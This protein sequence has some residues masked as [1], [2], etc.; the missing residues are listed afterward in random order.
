MAGSLALGPAVAAW[1]AAP[2]AAPA[3]AC[4]VETTADATKVT[5][6]GDGF[7][8][9]KV[10]LD[11]TDGAGGGSATVQSDG[12]FKSGEVS[13]G[14]WR[15]FQTSRGPRA[16]CQGGQAAQDTVNQR[17]IDSEQTRGTKEGWAQG[18]KLAQSGA[19]DSEPQPQTP[20]LQRLAPDAAGKKA[21]QEA[22][23]NAY[24]TA[25]R[26]AVDRFCP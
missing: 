16:N 21:A 20:N 22:Y 9:G 7:K 18:K 4:F 17:L 13:A 26:T 6:S 5:I 23:T 24:N 19:C 3:A 10:F 25:F 15:A 14:K 2:Q 8:K 1:G 11:Q 12:T